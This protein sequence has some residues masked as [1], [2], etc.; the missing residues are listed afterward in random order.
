[1]ID[2]GRCVMLPFNG[3]NVFHINLSDFQIHQVF[4]N[5]H[6]K[7]VNAVI[8]LVFLLFLGKDKIKCHSLTPSGC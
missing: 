6:P 1:M 3:S 7:D 4:Y 2:L 8:C 5:P